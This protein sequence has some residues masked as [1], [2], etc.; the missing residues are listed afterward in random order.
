MVLAAGE[1]YTH[2]FD[3][4]GDFRYMA[5]GTGYV[6]VYA[7]PDFELGVAPREQIVV[8]GATAHFQ[9]AVTPSWGFSTPVTL[10]VLD[11]PAGIS[12]APAQNPL[13]PPGN[14]ELVL[15]VQPTATVGSYPLRVVGIGAGQAHTAPI[16]VALTTDL[17]NLAWLELEAAPRDGDL[18]EVTANIHNDGQGWV[19][20]PFG[21]A[22]RLDPA[23][24]PGLPSEVSGTLSLPY[25]AAGTSAEVSVTVPFDRP[26]SYHLYGV[27][28]PSAAITETNESDNSICGLVLG[29]RSCRD[30]R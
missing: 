4:P 12:A 15:T 24:Q 13:L 1:S 8:R 27:L 28:D 29:A 6:H 11:L 3:L 20:R 5:V 16:T 10:G 17:P 18:L 23:W 26:G 7:V 14:T 19:D 2:T 30:V 25:L 21:V 22:W 9:V